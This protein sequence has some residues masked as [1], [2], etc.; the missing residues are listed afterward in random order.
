SQ[1]DASQEP[2]VASARLTER[3]RAL[4]EAFVLTDLIR[5]RI[6]DDSEDAVELRKAF[7]GPPS[8][9][10]LKDGTVEIEPVVRLESIKADLVGIFHFSRPLPFEGLVVTADREL[11]Y[12]EALGIRTPVRSL[13]PGR[14]A[15]VKVDDG[16]PVEYGQV[17]FEMDRS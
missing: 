5:L 1:D 14:V 15:S 7:G 10:D 4:A 11:A 12:V 8:V 9:V 2:S 17:L 6:E 3:I 16:Q 13:G